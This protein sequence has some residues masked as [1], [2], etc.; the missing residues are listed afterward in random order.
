MTGKVILA[1]AGP[2][3]PD[4]LTLGALKALRRA[5]AVF[6]DYLVHP[7]ILKFARPGALLRQVGKAH[8][9]RGRRPSGARSTERL[10]REMA[11]FARKGKTVVRLKGGDPYLFGRGAEEGEELAR[12]RVPFEVIPGVTSALAAPGCAGIPVTHRRMSSSVAIV[13]G[14]RAGRGGGGDVAWEKLAGA[15][16]TI[17]ILMGVGRI[18]T[19]ARRLL[20]AGLAR[21]TPVAA[22]RWGSCPEQE[23]RRGTLGSAGKVFARLKPPAVI[24]VGAVARL[25]PSPRQGRRRAGPKG[26]AGPAS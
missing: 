18:R 19:I 22:V 3:D 14:H 25:K 1:G 8:Y 2:G 21:S 24:V 16:G 5:D 12:L 26:G 4:L 10:A 6:H 20:A 17:V 9:G 15:V 11:S 7:A 13:T 23:T